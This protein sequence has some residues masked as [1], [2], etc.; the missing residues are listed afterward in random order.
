MLLEVAEENV[1]LGGGEFY[2]HEIIG[3]DV[4]EMMFNWE[5]K[6]ILQPGANDVWV[7]N[8]RKTRSLLFHQLLNVDVA[9]MC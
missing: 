4:Y 1:E 6:E 2:Y 5:I 3:L 9:M 7:V 8:V